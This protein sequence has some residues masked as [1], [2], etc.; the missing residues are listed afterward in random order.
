M[1]TRFESDASLR[2]NMEFFGGPIRTPTA[3]ES[4]YSDLTAPVF[5]A[6][7]FTTFREC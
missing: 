7:R 4:G 6:M 5:P 2:R 3:N 1:T